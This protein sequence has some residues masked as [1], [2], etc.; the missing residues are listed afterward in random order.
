MGSPMAEPRGRNSQ[1]RGAMKHVVFYAVMQTN[2]TGLYAVSIP[3]K[4]YSRLNFAAQICFQFLATDLA[5]MGGIWIMQPDPHTP[6]KGGNYKRGGEGVDAKCVRLAY[7]MS[8]HPP[9]ILSPNPHGRL[10]L[11][12]ITIEHC[13]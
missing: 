6:C 7:R 2:F 3:I 12:S 10:N 9:G 8:I 1:T 13:N 11:N 5:H 4:A